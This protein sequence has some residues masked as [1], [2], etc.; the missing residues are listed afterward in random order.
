MSDDGGFIPPDF[1]RNGP[2][3]QLVDPSTGA[4]IGSSENDGGW[5]RGPDG[6]AYPAGDP[7]LPGGPTYQP[8]SQPSTPVRTRTNNVVLLLLLDE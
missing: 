3:G 1:D 2:D 7:S 5:L 8:P 6:T 4:R